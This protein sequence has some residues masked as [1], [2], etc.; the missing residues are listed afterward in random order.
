MLSI[1]SICLI[2]CSLEMQRKLKVHCKL[3]FSVSE[4]TSHKPSKLAA[5]KNFS[6]SVHF[7][8]TTC[9]DECFW[10]HLITGAIAFGKSL[11]LL[12]D[13]FSRHIAIFFETRALKEVRILR[14][15]HNIIAVLIPKFQNKAIIYFT[16]QTF[17]TYFRVTLLRSLFCDCSTLFFINEFSL[18][19][20]KPLWKHVFYI[21]EFL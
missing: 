5:R 1:N 3:F 19:N 20:S 13:S 21:I 12:W 7:I 8:D 10:F 2:V 17:V 11:S 6:C 9:F 18:K 15:L 4:G 14:Y 16:G